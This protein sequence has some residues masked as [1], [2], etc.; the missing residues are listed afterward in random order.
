LFDFELKNVE[1]IEFEF[2]KK[3]QTVLNRVKYDKFFW[4]SFY[5]RQIDKKSE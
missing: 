2:H 3:E 5:K 1:E 4:D